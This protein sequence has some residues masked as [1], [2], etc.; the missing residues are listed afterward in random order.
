MN[1]MNFSNVHY[2]SNSVF[3][4]NELNESQYLQ[5]LFQALENISDD[6]LEEYEIYIFANYDKKI[7]PDSISLN[8]K[9]K[10]L[11]YLGDA[12]GAIDPRPLDR[13]FELIFKTHL[14]EEFLSEKILPV[15][16]GYVNDVPELPIQPIN[17][18]KLNVFFSGD[19][20]RNRIDLYRSFFPNQKFIP[21][22][23][24]PSQLFRNILIKYKYDFSGL[25]PDSLIVFNNGFKTGLSRLEYGEKLADSKIILSPM[26]FGNAECFRNIEAMRAGCVIISDKL[27]KHEFY[28][29]S[30]IIQVED[31]KEGLSWVKK[32]LRDK[33]MMKDYHLKTVDWWANKCS[34]I[35]MA[36]YMKEKISDIRINHNLIS[37]DGA[38]Q[39]C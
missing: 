28:E 34:E 24:L 17:E 3:K 26:G 29:G 36:G 33:E 18:R 38:V 9:K 20:N 27:P 16:L 32:L 8:T 11:Y 35:A 5:K 39:I 14:R 37:P 10:I 13:Y 19:L 30:P 2:D 23:G 6:L 25:F 21:K 22:R 31:W 7:I 12:A 15:S 1:K 4:L